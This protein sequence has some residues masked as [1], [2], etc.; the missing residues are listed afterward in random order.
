MFIA[1]TTKEVAYFGQ[2]DREQGRASQSDKQRCAR[3]DCEH[4]CSVQTAAQPQLTGIF[5]T[6]SPEKCLCDYLS[7]GSRQHSIPLFFPQYFTGIRRQPL[8]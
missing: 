5:L 2:R 3:L 8:L 1:R 4:G 7:K 6:F